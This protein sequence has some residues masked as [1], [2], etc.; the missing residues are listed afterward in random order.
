VTGD[1]A[2]RLVSVTRPDP[3]NDVSLPAFQEAVAVLRSG[4]Q[5]ARTL[6]AAVADPTFPV[7]SDEAARRFRA[8]DSLERHDDPG[9][10]RREF[11]NDW[12]PNDRK[13]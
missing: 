11:L 2:L 7:E 4:I 8:W 5:L 12:T 9:Q 3:Y 10:F 13:G 1:E 6:A